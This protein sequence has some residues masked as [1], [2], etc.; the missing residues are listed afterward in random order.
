M[1]NPAP[2]SNEST[3]RVAPYM[4]NAVNSGSDL[5]EPPPALDMINMSAAWQQATGIG[6]VRL[7]QLMDGGVF[8]SGRYGGNRS[9]C[10]AHGPALASLIGA[11]P[12]GEVT[13]PDP[14]QI[15]APPP[16]AAQIR[17][18]TGRWRRLH[19]NSR[20]LHRNRWSLPLL[21]LSRGTLPAVAAV[22]APAVAATAVVALAATAMAVRRS[23]RRRHPCRRALSGSHRETGTE[24]LGVCAGARHKP[25]VTKRPRR[26]CP[27][28][29]GSGRSRGEQGRPRSTDM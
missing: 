16:P 17:R 4:H 7:P 8:A 6:A 11:V 13:Q 22:V 27:R 25:G 18:H 23:R 29:N 24:P 3:H 9:D 19:Q 5:R 20:R 14:P 10:D 12:P 21:V 26:H 15:P 1:A 2:A 28:R